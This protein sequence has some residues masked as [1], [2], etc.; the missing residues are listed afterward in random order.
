MGNFSFYTFQSLAG[1]LQIKLSNKKASY[2]KTCGPE[3]IKLF[4]FI[5]FLICENETV[6]INYY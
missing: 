6:G 5:G 1:Q 2:H 3:K 4:S